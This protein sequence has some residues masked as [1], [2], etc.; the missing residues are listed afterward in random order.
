MRGL[1][2]ILAVLGLAAGP[3]VAQSRSN[4]G[5]PPLGA[6][7]PKLQKRPQANDL[8]PPARSVPSSITLDGKMWSGP[9]APADA[10]LPANARHLP[11]RPDFQRL[12][13]DTA[14]AA[15]GA[16]RIAV[17]VPA[18]AEGTGLIAG[19]LSD[20]NGQSLQAGGAVVF[21]CDAATG[22]P[23]EGTTK[24]PTRSLLKTGSGEAQPAFWFAVLDDR[25]SFEFRDVPPGRYRLIA[26]SWSGTT[27]LPKVMGRTSKFIVLH[28]VADNVEV[29][30]GEKTVV[31][32]RQLGEGTLRLK[33]NP[34]SPGA[35]LV[36]SLAPMIGD[37][38]LGFSGWGPN[39]TRQVIGVTHM[40]GPDVVFFG[41][42][43][44]RDL[45]VAYFNY[46]NS[47]GVAGGTFQAGP[48]DATLWVLAGWSNG[49][50]DPPPRLKPLRDHLME[51]ELTASNFLS[52]EEILANVPER[53]AAQFPREDAKT[54]PE[55]KRRTRESLLKYSAPAA[56]VQ[57]AANDPQREADIP[58]LGKQ[59]LID[60]AAALAYLQL[61]EFHRQRM[62]LG[63][64]TAPGFSLPEP[65]RK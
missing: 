43:E 54:P 24:Q 38:I 22:N 19:G 59:K 9:S 49:H 52:E 17:P 1:I 48:Q 46:D 5:S 18:T 44:H 45:H 28:G 61:R 20:I 58:G 47:P 64:Q 39:F 57:I 2:T 16:V 12:T 10:R 36:V 60:I 25:G 50:D 8:V 34:A 37:A 51:N 4:P 21:L 29:K 11:L 3:V 14:G 55:V 6:T 13:D 62:Q 26:Q 31:Y 63:R 41:V 15:S 42:P 56:L 7:A 40:A 32:L 35:F 65:G 30:D 23:I 27:G 53:L 33:T